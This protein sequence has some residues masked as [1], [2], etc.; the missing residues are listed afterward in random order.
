MEANA[1]FAVMYPTV[2]AG[3]RGKCFEPERAS[4]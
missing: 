1:S 3:L 4:G 2:T